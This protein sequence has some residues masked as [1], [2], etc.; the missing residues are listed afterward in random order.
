[1]IFRTCTCT[2]CTFHRPGLKLV[3]FRVRFCFNLLKGG[4]FK[5]CPLK[6][7]VGSQI[8]PGRLT[9]NLQITHL[10]RKIIWTKPPWLCSM[11]IFRGVTLLITYRRGLFIQLFFQT[12]FQ[13]IQ[14]SSSPRYGRT[15]R[16][17]FSLWAAEALLGQGRFPWGFQG[18][19]KDGLPVLSYPFCWGRSGK[20]MICI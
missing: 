14:F 17:C 12:T 15:S 8:H 16:R 4:P 2:T 7:S 20:V 13:D 6:I 9:W 5:F 1:M 18:F 3:V 19:S 10:E 11:L